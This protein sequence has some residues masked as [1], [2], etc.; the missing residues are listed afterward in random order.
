M[1][2]ISLPARAEDLRSAIEAR[3]ARTVTDSAAGDAKAL[4]AA[5]TDDA[6]MLALDATRVTGHA[7]IEAF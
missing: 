7:A 1:L 6:V 2:L 5:Y 3:N 4:A